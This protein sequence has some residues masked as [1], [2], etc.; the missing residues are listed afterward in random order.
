MADQLR[1]L[2]TVGSCPWNS[3]YV[4]ILAP[5][6]ITHGGTYPG[7]F[8][9]VGKH[10]AHPLY[11]RGRNGPQ[12]ADRHA[13]QPDTHTPGGAGNPTVDTLLR[14]HTGWPWSDGWRAQGGVTYGQLYRQWTD[15]PAGRD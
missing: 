1:T 2:P 11:G 4:R 15:W 7:Q 6:V 14:R 9:Y 8:G 10:R 3:A 13:F 12:R 5:E